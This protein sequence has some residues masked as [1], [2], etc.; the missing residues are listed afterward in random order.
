MRSWL[1][2]QQARLLLGLLR[3]LRSRKTPGDTLVPCVRQAAPE[4]ACHPS[5]GKIMPQ[6]VLYPWLKD[7]AA[8]THCERVGAIMQHLLQ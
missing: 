3:V 6:D 1:F 8:S 2:H 7:D 5:D 4:G